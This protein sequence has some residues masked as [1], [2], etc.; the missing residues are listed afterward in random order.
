MVDALSRRDAELAA[1]FALS[2]P[3]FDVFNTLRKEVT[4]DQTLQKLSTNIT[5]GC[6]GSAW[7]VHV[8]LITVGRKVYVPTDS[9][10]VSHML[11]QA[12]D[13]SHEGVQRTRQRLRADFR[14]PGDKSLVQ[15]YMQDCAICQQNKV[16][17]LQPTGLLQPLQIPTKIWS[18][19]SMVFIEGL[20]QVNNK[21]VILIVVD[22]LSKLAHFIP[23]DI[24][25]LLV[26]SPRFFL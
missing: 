6:K 3:L 8:D 23:L 11:D 10:T 17:H 19:I 21:S 2:T 18:D 14:I 13:T 5:T 1:T 20:P 22:R 12:H 16:S 25:T 24:L 15:A 9:P 4:T 26:L 7:A